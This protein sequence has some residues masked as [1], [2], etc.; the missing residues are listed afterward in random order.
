[1]QGTGR[2]PAV[3]QNRRQSPADWWWVGKTK[4]WLIP[5]TEDLQPY[6]P[7][8]ALLRKWIGSLIGFPL[9]AALIAGVVSLLV[10]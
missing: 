5:G 7:T 8:R 6:I 1:M 3:T 9:L 10:G 4:A 2:L